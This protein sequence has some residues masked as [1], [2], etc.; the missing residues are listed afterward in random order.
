M[1]GF[2]FCLLV[3]ATF[4]PLESKNEHSTEAATGTA[5]SSSLTLDVT[6]SVASVDLTVDS[7]TGTFASSDTNAAFSVTTNNFTGYT[8]SISADEDTGLLSDDESNT[9]SSIPAAI[10]EET[11]SASANTSYNGMWGYRPSKYNSVANTNYLPA[12]TTTAST[13]DVTSA[14][15]TTANNYTIALGARA[16][17]TKPA[18]AYTNTFTIIAVSNPI[19]YVIKYDSNTTDTVTDMPVTQSSSTSATSIILSNNT[20]KREHYTFNGWCSVAPTTT[21]GDDVCNGGTVYLSGAVYGIDKTTLND[22]TLYAMWNI[23]KFVQT[24]QVRYEN[25][26]GTW[27][28]YTTVDTKTINYGSNYSWSTSQIDNFNTTIYKAGSVAEYTVTAAKTN[29]VSIYRQTYECKAQYKLQAADGTYPSTYT[30]VTV[31][32]ALRY[33]STCSYTTTQ[34][35]AQ[36]TNQ[37]AS[38][39]VNG[40]TTLTLP[41]VPRKTYALTVTAGTNT[42]AATGS[43]TYRYGQVVTVGVTKATNT[44]C[45]SY[46]TPTWAKSTGATGTLSATSGTS[47]TYTMGTT[48]DTITATSTKSNVQQ[49]ITLSRSNASS[50][51]IAGTAYTASS[52]KLTCGTYNITGAFPTG[53]AFSKWAATK[54][55]LG[56]ATTLATTYQVTEPAT[57]TLTGAAKTNLALTVNFNTSHVSQVVVREGSTT[58]TVKATLTTSGK[59]SNLTYNTNYYLIPTYKSGYELSAWSKD[60]GTVGTLSSTT[61]ANPYYKIGDGTNA[62]TLTAKKLYMQ[63]MTAS[64]CTTTAKTAYD[65]RDEEAY[66]VQKLV[67]GK[68]WMLDNL[69]LGGT[70]AISLT[71]SNTNIAKNYTLP[72]SS[73]GTNIIVSNYTNAA[74]NADYKNTVASIKYGSGS[75][76][77]GVYYNY[78]AATAGTYCY[79]SDSGTGNA[80]YDVCPKGWRMPT[81]GSSGEYQALYAAYNNMTNFHNAFSTLLSGNV[82]A[83]SVKNQGGR[84]YFWSSTYYGPS[85]M[86]YWGVASG[87]VTSTNTYPRSNGYSVRCV[88]K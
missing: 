47:V 32:S 7:S 78:C 39:T 31:D 41:N 44:T 69:R 28:S 6:S 10:S 35:T 71:T 72:A 14:A 88:L 15:N 63:N 37:T 87:N 86:Y 75:G 22:T 27:G 49:T 21:N 2:L 4:Y 67:D 61:A 23:D 58:G 56:S 76:K 68:C 51:S 83:G 29:Q 38:A 20:P 36:Y 9:L 12:P 73:G 25:A 3:L 1:S 74:I 64:D 77:I 33:G 26:D 81:G 54:G 40:T 16:D 60:G 19:N 82:N 42:S 18:S 30:T 84:G 17:F 79:A 43:G 85:I 62:V 65:I 59:V 45:I 55:T 57:L 70:S 48:A 8:L 52:V 46:A 80:S 34:N 24:T 53:Y 66:L 50:I 11:F 13:L 5:Q